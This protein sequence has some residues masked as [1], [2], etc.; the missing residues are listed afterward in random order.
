MGLADRTDPQLPQRPLQVLNLFGYTGLATLAAAAAGARVTHV[1]ASR[2][3]V[4]WARENQELSG[5]ARPA[6]PLDYG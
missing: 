4:N 2:K 3:V 6:G 1:D 5:L